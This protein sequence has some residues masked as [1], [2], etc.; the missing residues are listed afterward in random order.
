MPET[1]DLGNDQSAIIRTELTGADEKWW[2]IA[3]DAAKR[4][5]GTGKPARTEVDP[6]NPAQMRTVPAVAAEITAEDNY[7]L[8]DA[9]ITRLMI[10][11]T[12][13]GSLPWKPEMRDTLTLEQIQAIDGAVIRQMRRIQGLGPKPQKTGPTS[14]TSSP[15]T[16]RALPPMPTPAPSS[17]APGS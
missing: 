12:L 8:T 3:V 1:I 17:T 10:S 13:P 11:W 14:G 2:F 9:L 5:N 16:A 7:M 4:A 6:D 15:D